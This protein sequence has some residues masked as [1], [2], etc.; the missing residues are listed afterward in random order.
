MV[1]TPNLCI[2]CKG[3]RYL[4][5][6][7]PC[8]L[9]ARFKVLPKVKKSFKKEF[10]GPSPS[11]FIGYTGYPKVSVGPMASLD[12]SSFEEPSNWYGQDYSKIIENRSL[13]IRSK[14]SESIYSSSK[15]VK[16]IQDISVA[17][18]P[19]DVELL[20]KDKPKYKVSFSNITQPEGPIANLRK[21]K[22]TENLKIKRYVDKIISDELKANQSAGLLYKKGEDVYKISTILSSGILGTKKKRLVPTRW[23][24][25]AVDDLVAKQ[26]MKKVRD[27]PSIN[28]YQVFKSK[29]LDNK[30]VI[31]L[32]P[33]KWEYEN[34]ESW[35]P[36]STWYQ[37]EGTEPIIIEEYEPF[38]GRTKY[39]DKETGGYYAARLGVVEYL[40]S[41]KR[42]ARVVV[43][44]EI[45]PGYTIPM[46]VW[47]VRETARNSFKNPPRKFATLDKSLE[48]IKDEIKNPLN[49]YI[50][51][52]RILRQKR[53]SD[54]MK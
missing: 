46:G 31:L 7:K 32:I 39:A 41:I 8:P 42:Q 28:E 49:L 43:F 19:T 17:S 5:G 52:S 10:L 6:H 11:I 35:A 16:L 22:L 54:F 15:I 30:F 21:A 20:F 1:K 50:Q 27:F 33:G 23:S 34:F 9:M 38:T 24:I 18:K 47:V 29:Y 53:L 3:S 13:N 36:G 25:T 26:L 48:Y 14:Y 12:E 2:V 4:C 40:A 45:S 51:N 37:G 44:R